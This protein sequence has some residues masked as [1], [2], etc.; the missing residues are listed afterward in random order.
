[1]SFKKVKVWNDDDRDY[2][3]VFK[4]EEIKIPAHG[5]IVMTRHDAADFVSR[6]VNPVDPK[7]GQEKNFK[8]LRREPILEDA[9][10]DPNIPKTVCIVCN[11]DCGTMFALAGHVK[12]CHSN[13]I[14]GESKDDTGK[15]GNTGEKQV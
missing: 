2:S 15:S 13:L 3:E 14:P 12:K 10:P 9:K 8:K 6:W 5:Y 11:K 1:M 7:T 4:D